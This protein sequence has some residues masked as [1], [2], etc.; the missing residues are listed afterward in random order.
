MSQLLGLEARCGY[1]GNLWLKLSHEVTVLPSGWDA[2]HP[3][4]QPGKALLSGPPG[5][6][7]EFRSSVQGLSSLL[8]VAQQPPQILATGGSPQDSSKHGSHFPQSEGARGVARDGSH[9]LFIP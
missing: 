4:S 9:S 5:G 2:S 8:T 1:T 6:L 3:K 7:T